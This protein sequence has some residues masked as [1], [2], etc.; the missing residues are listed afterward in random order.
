[1]QHQNQAVVEGKTLYTQRRP[2]IDGGRTARLDVTELEDHYFMQRIRM[3]GQT[4][5][6]GQMRVIGTAS[7]EFARGTLDITDRQN[8]QLHWVEIENIPELWRRLDEVGL[9]TVEACGDTPRGFLVSPVAG[10]EPEEVIDP[11]EA[12]RAIHDT[13]LGN[14]EIANLPR[15]FKT[16]FTGSPTL[17]VLHEI[18]DISYVGVDHPELGPGYDLWIAGAPSTRA[19][20]DPRPAT[21]DFAAEFFANLNHIWTEYPIEIAN[22]IVRGLYP[23]T[24]AAV[25]KT[26]EIL[27]TELPGALHRV[28][29]ECKDQV[30]RQLAAQEFNNSAS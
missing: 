4:L 1:V 21:P 22:R 29:L 3:D 17:D 16:A 19:P 23:E 6:V 26:E 24:A 7:N 18:N 20:P 13:Y 14:P 25:A 10:I 8:L 15:K 28:L 11:S 2:G 12:A 27:E 9:T 5:S 30:Q